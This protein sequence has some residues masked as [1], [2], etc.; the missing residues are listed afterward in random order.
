MTRFRIFHRTHYHY[1]HPVTEGVSETRLTPFTD[2]RQRLLSFELHTSPLGA[3]QEDRDAF[4]NIYQTLWFPESHR[5]LIIEA[6]SLVETGAFSEA[7]GLGKGGGQAAVNDRSDAPSGVREAGSDD[8]TQSH[9]EW[10]ME[11]S[12]CPFLPE[13]RELA[14]DFRLREGGWP[15][16]LRLA[17]RLYERYAYRQEATQVDSSIR[18]ILHQGAGVC[19]DFSHLMAAA[20]RVGG[21]PARYVSGY[22]PCGGHLRGESASHAWVEAWLPERGWVGIDPT[23]NC[24]VGALHVKIAHGRD[25]GDIVPVKGVYRGQATQMLQVSVDAQ[26]IQ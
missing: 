9:A 10:L 3:V 25:Y 14:D 2:H 19:Q 17:E 6:C 11:T 24:P 22:I 1:S 7:E 4:G 12:Y 16:I 13:V 20:L 15:E 26:V 5:E 23:N 18:E 8:V 21:V